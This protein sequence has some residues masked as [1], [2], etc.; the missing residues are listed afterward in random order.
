M[1]LLGD[2]ASLE[3][4]CHCIGGLWG[5]FFCCC[6][7]LFVFRDRVSLYNPGCPGT[8]SADQAG[9]ELRHPPAS[10]SQ[11]LGLKACTTTAQHPPHLP[12]GGGSGLMLSFAQCRRDPATS[13]PWDNLLLAVFGSDVEF[14]NPPA[15]CLLACY[16]ACCH[17]DNGL[18]H[19]KC[20]PVTIKC[21]P[22]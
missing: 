2:V 5:F 14:L 6:C 18:N 17:D 12:G 20:K 15:S 1:A 8:H 11:V 4:V 10:A 9:L 3:E 22:L 19:W 7:C 13:C 21:C 16:Y